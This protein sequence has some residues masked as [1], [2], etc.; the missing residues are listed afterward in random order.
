MKISDGNWL[1]QPNFVLQNP[2]QLYEYHF[3][4][5]SGKLVVYAAAQEV[6]SDRGNQINATLFTLEITSPLVGVIGVKFVHHAGVVDHG[7][8]HEL[9]TCCKAAAQVELTDS[10]S[11]IEYKSG[12][13]T[14]RINKGAW[15]IDFLRDGKRITGSEFKNTGYVTDIKN[16]AHYCFERLD[17]GVNEWVYGL[18]ERFTNTVKNGQVVDIWN[19]DGGTSTEQAYKNIPFYLTNKGYGVFVN[20]PGK[21]SFEVASEK[22]SK[23]QFSVP[24]ESLEYFVIDGPSPKDVLVKYTDLT[25]KP[26]LPPA[27]SF[28]L[29]LTTSF[30]TNYD[31]KTVNSFIDGMAERDLPLHVFHFDCF[32]M[33]GFEWCNFTWDK[34]CFPDPEGMLARLHNDKKLKVC[35]WI[36]PYIGQKSPLFA[37]GMEKGYFIKRP[38]GDVW[39]WDLWQSGQAIVDFTNPE[40]TKWYQGKLKALLDMGVD[41][42]KTDFGER[43]PTD[44][45]YHNG[46]DPERMHNY[47]TYLY[48]KAVFEVLEGKVGKGNAVLF[49]RSAIAGGQQFPA[50]WGGDCYATYESMAETLRGGLSLAMSGF[51]FWS[52]DIGGFENTAP[53]DIYKRWCAFGL[54]S[55]H[56]RLHGSKSY[57][58][59]WNYD[60]EACDVLRYFTKLKCSLMPYLYNLAREA[61]ETGIPLLR[62]M[63]LEFPQ[64]R[65]CDHLDTQYM[66]G[67]SL[68]VAPIFSESGEVDVYLPRGKWTSL[69]TNEVKEGNSFYHE[70]HGYLSLPLYVRENTLLARGAIDNKPDYEYNQGTKF[71]LFALQDGAEA[72]AHVTNLQG[73][74]VYTLKAARCGNTIAFV[75]EGEAQ[76]ISILLRNVDVANATNATVT[77]SE[78]GVVIT[79]NAST[80]CTVEL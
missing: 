23:V 38:N 26:A 44:V 18:G 12:N 9:H 70:K 36:N 76:N 59:P 49:A 69:I 29:W 37:E 42:F 63:P 47:Y 57:R 56:S 6:L 4:K 48:N 3:D 61:H 80:G 28:G 51:S 17:L 39:Q 32:W 13:L 7:P 64:E 54:L 50:H 73:Q 11:A 78:L 25:G 66:M 67:D 21:V 2:K 20:H 75:G 79:P 58:V 41:C 15:S 74:V 35:V 8:H 46:A 24:G 68:L 27:W 45:V 16:P 34:A 22:V 10:E 14:L 52:H 30:T 19:L 55:S 62:P 33:A 40:A 31:E 77:K 5:E 71:E 65:A 60:D 72:V 43:I 53:A 1:I